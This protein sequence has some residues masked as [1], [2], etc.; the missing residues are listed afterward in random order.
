MTFTSYLEPSVL[1]PRDIV[2][3]DL[4]TG[5]TDVELVVLGVGIG[6]LGV[7]ALLY[8]STT[9]LEVVLEVVQVHV[10]RKRLARVPSMKAVERKAR[11][12]RETSPRNRVLFNVVATAIFDNSGRRRGR[13]LRPLRELE[14]DEIL[15]RRR[16]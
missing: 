9:A 10:V 13:R 15:G 12:L 14:L 8:S 6:E 11:D 1:V 3:L 7:R 2:R 4:H 16:P 5:F